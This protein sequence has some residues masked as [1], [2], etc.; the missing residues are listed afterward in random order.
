M[1]GTPPP[2][3]GI[4]VTQGADAVTDRY[5][6]RAG[7]QQVTFVMTDERDAADTARGLAE[8]GVGLIELYGDFTDETAAAVI[9]GVAGRAAVGVSGRGRDIARSPA[10]AMT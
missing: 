5:V 1:E 4:V 7:A 9:E 6:R 8:Q 10:G 2:E 3:A